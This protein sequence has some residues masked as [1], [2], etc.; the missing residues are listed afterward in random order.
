MIRLY[1]YDMNV[2]TSFQLFSFSRQ[3]AIWS[4]FGTCFGWKV[5]TKGF[6]WEHIV[7]LCTVVYYAVSSGFRRIASATASI[8]LACAAWNVPRLNECNKQVYLRR[9]KIGFA[10]PLL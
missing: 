9:S 1:L 4:L 3:F 6:A 8:A 10:V 7:S 5:K 2:N